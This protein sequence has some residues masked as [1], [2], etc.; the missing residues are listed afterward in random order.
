MVCFNY[1]LSQIIFSGLRSHAWKKKSSVNCF[2]KGHLYSGHHFLV[3]STA[4]GRLL[5]FCEFC[6]SSDCQV[7]LPCCYGCCC[8]CWVLYWHQTRLLQALTMDLGGS[9]GTVLAFGA[10]LETAGTIIFI[11]WAAT[12]LLASVMPDNYYRASPNAEA[13]SL[14]DQK[15]TG[16]SAS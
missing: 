11:D 9:P 4:E 12:V 1:N 8:C 5:A 10:K 6:F 16:F 15:T 7:D 2:R 14:E 13:P 3:E